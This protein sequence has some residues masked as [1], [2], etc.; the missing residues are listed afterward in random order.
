LPLRQ[1][2]AIFDRTTSARFTLFFI[3]TEMD[4]PRE[5]DGLDLERYREYLRTLARLQIN[6]RLRGKLDLSGV[7]QQT[8]LEAHQA[9]DK[10][11]ELNDAQ[12]A[13]WMRRAL[14]N[15]L[16]DEARRLGAKARDVSREQSLQHALDE[17]SARLEALLA[18]EQHSPSQH[19]VQQE[20]LLRLA[21]A[22]GRL[23]EDQRAVVELHHLEGRTLAETAETLGRTR[24]AVASLVFRGLRNLRRL[25][26]EQGPNDP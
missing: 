18:V 10:L 25:L 8:L 17:S 14:A 15:N 3:G 23:P 20:D 12:R 22:L 21:E 7:V 24:S 13:A 1:K 6:D 2:K 4:Q 19:A 16:A 9:E 5:P 26:D 11:R